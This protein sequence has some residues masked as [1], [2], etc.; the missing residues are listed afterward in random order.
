M[1]SIIFNNYLKKSNET[2]KKVNE[3]LD[4]KDLY[5]PNIFNIINTIPS[6]NV[7][8]YFLLVL[9]IYAFL[10]SREIRINDIFIFM[11][12]V[13]VVYLLIQKDYV[14]FI[15]FTDNKK[16]QI[17]FLEKLL[18]NN[19]SYETAIIG[20]ESLTINSPNVKT[21]YFYYDPIIIEFYYNIREVINYDISSYINSL[22]HTNNLLK[23]SYQSNIL[24]ENLKENYEQAIIEKDKALNFLSY[25]IFSIPV[26]NIT[27]K[28]YNDSI[29][30]LHSRLN[31]H[32]DNMA[33]LFKDITKQKNNDTSMYLPTDTFEKN[34]NAQ[35]FD[36]DNRKS[37]LVH[38]LY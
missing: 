7:L 3:F 18:F 8:F 31:A 14:N 19:N 23:I 34:N 37:P 25:M 15:Q 27:Y 5:I 2:N 17:K 38:D 22:T 35:P 33:I 36:K 24:K 26:N 28:K 30:I 29:N 4:K 10:R 32:I 13:L 20:G 1:S 11:V 12:C 6:N 16:I 21:S 9:L